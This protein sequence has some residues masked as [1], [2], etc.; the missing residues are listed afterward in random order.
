MRCFKQTIMAIKKKAS[1]NANHTEV[2]FEI[3]VNHAPS[4]SD[5]YLLGDFNNWKIADPDFEMEKKGK[6]FSKTISLKN[7]SK[8]EFRYVNKNFIW[9]NDEKA[10]DYVPSPFYGVDN[11]VIDLSKAKTTTPPKKKA[12]AKKTAA[13]SGK[14]NL[15]KIE[16]IGPKIATLLIDKGIETFK[17]LSKASVKKL[18]EILTS[19]GSRY[20]M[21]KPK[22]WPEQA[23]LAAA[24]KWEDLK[25][26]QDQLNG[27]K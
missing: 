10:D 4:K 5:I 9:F 19:A 25:V 2:T 20:A 3:N 15:T 13:Q 18:E 1:K 23:K 24:G 22:T 11:C 6:F 14:D 26:L 7:G 16:G 27:G 17:D 8:Y 21:H 12:V